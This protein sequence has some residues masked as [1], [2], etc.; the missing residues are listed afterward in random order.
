MLLAKRIFVVLLFLRICVMPA[1]AGVG[2]ADNRYYVTD[3][4]WAQDPYNKFVHLTPGWFY[5][6]FEYKQIDDTMWQEVEAE[7]FMVFG[8]CS[9]QY[10]SPNLILSAGHCIFTEKE[11]QE[12]VLDDSRI[13]PTYKKNAHTGYK[14]KN[15]KKESFDMYLVD[16]EYKGSA[17]DTLGDWAVWLV[18]DPEYYSDAYFDV[19]VPTKTIDVINAGWGWARIFSDEELEN[20][21]KIYDDI[22]QAAFKENQSIAISDL[23]RQISD[24][25]GSSIADTPNKLKASECKIVFEDCT[26]LIEDALDLAV[27]S[28]KEEITKS[29]QKKLEKQA[30]KNSERFKTIC[31]S[32]RRL[33]RVSSYPNI[34]ATTCD[35][36]GGNSGG[37]YVSKDGNF[38]YGTCSYG[39]DGFEDK[40]NTDYIVSSKQFDKRIKDLIKKYDSKNSVEE[41]IAKIPTN[42]YGDT[43]EASPESNDNNQRMLKRS[44]TFNIEEMEEELTKQLPNIPSMSNEQL[45]QFVDKLAEYEDKTKKL[46]ELQKAYDEAKEREQS[47]A[48]RTLTAVTMAATGIGGME[49][50]QGLAEQKADKDAE[51][52]MTAYMETFRCE[53]GGGKSVKG[54]T[55]EIQLPADTLFDLY[56][57]YIT[58]A[59]DLKER[60]EM[61]G[62]A[63]GIESEV[64]IDKATA[65]LYD[66]KA[67][68][69]SNGTYAS[70]YRA[71]MGNET[72]Q[73][74]LQ[75]MADT[76]KK[77]V[78]GGAI[79]AGV[80]T[81]VGII[82]N[83]MINGKIGEAIKDS[84]NKSVTQ[85]NNQNVAK[86]FING[87]K[88]AGITNADKLN[89]DNIDISS[90]NMK[91][92]DFTKLKQYSGQDATKLFNTTNAT[93]FTSSLSGIFGN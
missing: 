91:D 53:Y 54:G 40:Y 17:F 34:L 73:A 84:K 56:Q 80:G 13:S 39:G 22:A 18:T 10:I 7:R 76:S 9:A 69:I 3:E 32:Q 74:K 27:E 66:D 15:Y 33:N 63:P 62:L 71:K 42:L 12:I 19:K 6:G 45:L 75:E 59:A 58:L 68:E 25:F 38:I 50:A 48:N 72:D 30:I 29:K 35:S 41:N 81:G 4:M 44:N 49:L 90:L 24:K 20:L 43:Y 86:Q 61:L 11:L 28:S 52:D 77:R 82:G 21:R 65:G 88:S 89:F 8:T 87:L 64:I 92:M 47:L 36:W 23:K 60:K 83:S 5:T 16:T 31:N 93:S 85:K 26:K 55:A 1:I 37:G 70:I 46:E 2:D 67:S 79:A 57:E 51:Q 78:T 14:G